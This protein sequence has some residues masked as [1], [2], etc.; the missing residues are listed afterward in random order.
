MAESYPPSPPKLAQRRVDR[1]DRGHG[2]LADP[3]LGEDHRV[4]VEVTAPRLL[5]WPE[6][7]R[8][9]GGQRRSQGS[10]LG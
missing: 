9:R 3:G 4:A 5:G 8:P 2:D 6:L 7:D 10:Q 1:R